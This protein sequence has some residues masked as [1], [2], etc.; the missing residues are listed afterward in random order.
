MYRPTTDSKKSVYYDVIQHP[1][2][3]IRSPIG[4]R[5]VQESGFFFWSVGISFK[6]RRLL[7][8]FQRTTNVWRLPDAIASFQHAVS[9]THLVIYHKTRVVVYTY[10]RIMLISLYILGHQHRVGQRRRVES[11][12]REFDDNRRRRAWTHLNTTIR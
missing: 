6:A 2:L 12:R 11:N 1:F 7:A 3:R 5:T 9:S 8:A 4:K 10:T